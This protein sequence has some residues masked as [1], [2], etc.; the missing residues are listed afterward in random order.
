MNSPTVYVTCPA[1]EVMNSIEG[2]RCQVFCN[3]D[4]GKD[5]ARKNA[6]ASGAPQ[7]IYQLVPVYL[8]EVE[9]TYNYPVKEFKAP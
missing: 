2:E 9:V 3:I 5:L 6:E 1:N 4:Y 7:V 8:V